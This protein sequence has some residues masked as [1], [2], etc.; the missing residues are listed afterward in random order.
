MFMNAGLLAFLVVDMVSI[1]VNLFPASKQLK[2][3]FEIEDTLLNHAIISEIMVVLA[4]LI[5]FAYPQVMGLFGLAGGLA[6]TTI[7]W[8]VPFLIGMSMNRDKPW[9]SPI[10]ILLTIGI[11]A[12]VFLSIASTTATLFGDM[13]ENY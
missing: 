10:K 7:G 9:Y 11:I 3:Y 6:C 12:F 5:I 13:L 4:S 8:T 1:T 2:T